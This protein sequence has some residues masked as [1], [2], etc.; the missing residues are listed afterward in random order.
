MR[1]KKAVLF[2]LVTIFTVLALV[3]V[4]IRSRKM[5]TLVVD[6]QHVNH[7]T[8]AWTVEQA[9]AEAGIAIT[10]QDLIQ[11]SLSS[12]ITNGSIIKIKR[13]ATLQIEVDNELYTFFAINPVPADLLAQAGIEISPEDLLLDGLKEIPLNQPFFTSYQSYTWRLQRAT[14]FKLREDSNVSEFSSPALT[15]GKA[16]WEQGISLKFGDRLEPSAGA[17]LSQGED[18]LL[19]RAQPI[20]LTVGNETLVFTS[21]ANLVNEAIIDA[22]LSLQGLDYTIPSESEPIPEDRRIHL[23]RVREEIIIEQNPIPFETVYQPAPNL[24]I[25]RQDVLQAGQFGLEAQRIRVRYEDEQEVTRQVEETWVAQTPLEKIIGYGTQVVMHS[26]DTPDG[27]VNYWRALQVYA[28]SYSPASTGSNITSTG[29]ILRKGI[30]AVN[31]RYIPYG[32]VLYVPGYGFGVAADTGNLTARWIDLGYSEE[33][34]IGWHHNV[35]V[36]FVWP[37][38]ESIVWVI[39]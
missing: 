5:V 35:T 22:G 32:T 9:I 14:P 8:W 2:G 16:L 15:V 28:T 11:P 33:D 17:R 18:I 7:A 19:Q 10:P 31:P 38:P 1:G 23:V 29:Q 4:G 25:D 27:V 3:F 12:P 26:I 36:Y 34:Y 37:P 6:Q 13:A 30:I 21:A 24:E 20:T 39:P